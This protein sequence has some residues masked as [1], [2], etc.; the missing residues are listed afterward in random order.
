[1]SRDRKG[2]TLVIMCCAPTTLFDCMVAFHSIF[3]IGH[4]PPLSYL[5]GKKFR[6]YEETNTNTNNKQCQY[7][8]YEYC[9]WWQYFHNKIRMNND[10]CE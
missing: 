10:C 9:A 1:M 3:S 2:K 8:W 5:H 7:D 6:K 4:G